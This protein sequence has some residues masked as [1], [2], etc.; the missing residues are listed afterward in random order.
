MRIK[1][2]FLDNKEFLESLKF[3]PHEYEDYMH[4]TPVIYKYVKSFGCGDCIELDPE[5]GY[6]SFIEPRGRYGEDS[7]TV[8]YVPTFAFCFISK[9]FNSG[10]IEE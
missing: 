8:P 6:L 2:E 10:V 9:L 5:S 3:I 1:K 7:E 4:D